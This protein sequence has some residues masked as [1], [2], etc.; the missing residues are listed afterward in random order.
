[1][2]KVNK[3]NIEY[4][5]CSIDEFKKYIED[6]FTEKINWGSYT[7]IWNMHYVKPIGAKNISEEE[8]INRLKFD[9]IKIKLMKEKIEDADM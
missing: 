3:S 9:N 4:L 5:G 2:K 8:L 1:M 7:K 6:Q